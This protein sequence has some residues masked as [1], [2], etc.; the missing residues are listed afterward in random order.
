MEEEGFWALIAVGITP[1]PI[2]AGTLA[3]GFA[4]YSFSLF[5]LAMILSRSI[6]YY[7]VA[8]LAVFAGKS[9]PAF[10]EKHKSRLFVG[11]MIACIVLYAGLVIVSY[12]AG[13]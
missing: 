8:A 5:L 4:E 3:A 9:A 10:F 11:G 6:R 12:M 1:L 13:D 7:G 2:Q